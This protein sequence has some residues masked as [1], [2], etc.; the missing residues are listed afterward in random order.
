M[1]MR[2]RYKF[3]AVLVLLFLTNQHVWAL[4]QQQNQSQFPKYKK[5]TPS[6]GCSAAAKGAGVNLTNFMGAVTHMVHSITVQ[7]IRYFFDERFPEAND[8]STVNTNLTDPEA[9]LTYAPSKPSVFKFPGG[10][11]FD[12]VMQENDDPTKYFVRGTTHLE[13]LAHWFHMAE[14]WHRA[15]RMYKDIV[16]RVAAKAVEPAAVCPCLLEVE[17]ANIRPLL[18]NV[19]L[20]LRNYTTVPGQEEVRRA[21]RDIRYPNTPRPQRFE[22]SALDE[23]LGQ[24]VVNPLPVGDLSPDVPAPSPDVPAPSSAAGAHVHDEVEFWNFE[25]DPDRSI[26][27]PELRDA[28]S[29][30]FWKNEILEMDHPMEDQ[31]VFNFAMYM[32]CKIRNLIEN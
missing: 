24:I 14:M 18:E 7:D 27:L 26:E 5:Y 22:R 12:L 10:A 8:V 11:H 15:S 29:W 9:V 32:F 16:A 13:D 3:L 1:G 6:P 2:T 4:P 25:T 21:P 23:P 19:A 17:A 20:E 31:G 30:K 28:E